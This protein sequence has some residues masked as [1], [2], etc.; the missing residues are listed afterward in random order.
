MG[1]NYYWY[2][3]PPCIRCGREYEP[4]HIGKSSAG[5]CFGLHVFPDE[6]INTIQDWI[7]KWNLPGSLIFDE[8]GGP[9]TPIEMQEIVTQRSWPP[10]RKWSPKEMDVNHASPGPHGLVRHRIDGQ[11]T[12][13][14][15][16]G[17]WDYEVGDFS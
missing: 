12:I 6:G 5:W 3:Q 15:G 9:L 11:H 8:Y 7:D 10:D 4:K 13:G 14:H 2:E 1:T 17:T 16:E